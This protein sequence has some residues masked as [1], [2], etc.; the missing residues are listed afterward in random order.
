MSSE[1]QNF[2]CILPSGTSV[3]C[4]KRIILTPMTLP[5][6]DQ[7]FSKKKTHLAEVFYANISE[8]ICWILGKISLNA[9]I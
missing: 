9:V 4:A 6:G 8:S 5:Q 7:N 1:T 3:S 2:L